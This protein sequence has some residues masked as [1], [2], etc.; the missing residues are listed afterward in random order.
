MFFIMEKTMYLKGTLE[1]SQ[2]FNNLSGPLFNK[3]KIT[4]KQSVEHANKI[5]RRACNAV[6]KT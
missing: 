6:C 5:P 2:L 3:D 1:K 4:T